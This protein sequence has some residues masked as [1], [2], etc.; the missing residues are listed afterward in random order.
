MYSPSQID[1]LVQKNINDFFPA[2][3]VL[4][5]IGWISLKNPGLMHRPEYLNAFNFATDIDEIDYISQFTRDAD[6]DIVREFYRQTNGMRLFADRF[7]VPGVLFHR[8]DFY[9]NDFNCV[10]LDFSNHGGFALPSHSPQTGLLIGQSHRSLDGKFERLYD[11]LTNSGEIIGGYFDANPE[12]TDRFESIDDWLC[13]RIA[14]A[15]RELQITI[16]QL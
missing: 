7:C 10:A 8:N 6:I 15:A 14:G 5:N 12:V 2:E 3:R 13:Y 9:G 1:T 4:C 16:A 11:I